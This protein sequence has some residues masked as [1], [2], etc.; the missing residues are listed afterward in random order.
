MKLLTD[1][2]RRKFPPFHS[3]DGKDPKD[4]PV[5]AK[6]FNPVGSG[7][8]YAVESGAQ[9]SDGREVPLTETGSLPE[10]VTV[11]DITFFG[12]ANIQEPELGYFSL[13]ELESV[14]FLGGALGIERD[15]HLGEITLAEA[16][17]REGMTVERPVA[18]AGG[19]HG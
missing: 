11:E 10:G 12:L 9:L 13:A 4:V 17:R 2:L 14:R 18:A 3:T 6:F 1:E 7:T 16:K 15:L 19:D 8:W 5:I